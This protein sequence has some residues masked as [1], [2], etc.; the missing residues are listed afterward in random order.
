MRKPPGARRTVRFGI[1]FVLCALGTTPLT[2]RGQVISDGMAEVLRSLRHPQDGNVL[3]RACVRALDVTGVSMSL[4]VGETPQLELL[5]FHPVLSRR[6]EDLQLTLGEGPG[7]DAVRTGL[8]VHAP[9]LRR[10]RPDRWPLLVP[11]AEELG[12]GGV[13]CFPLGVGAVRL[14][15]LTVLC[16]GRGLS[17][18]QQVDATVLAAALTSGALNSA[19]GSGAVDGYGVHEERGGLHRAA[20]HQATGMISV[21]LNVPMAQAMLRLRAHSYASGRPLGEV[22]ADVVARR[23]RFSNDGDDMT[24]PYSPD[25]GKG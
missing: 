10:V 24:G 2:E 5:W 19:D 8:A 9:D 14:G 21:Q 1:A 7:P 25:G 23:L 18:Q 4:L 13:S 11:S 15:V 3:A 17:E 22:A 20:V 6:F 16:D 12:V